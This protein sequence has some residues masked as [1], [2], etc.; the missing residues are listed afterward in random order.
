MGLLVASNDKLVAGN[1]V[2]SFSFD[3]FDWSDIA[4]H[5]VSILSISQLKHFAV[6]KIDFPRCNVYAIFWILS[7]CASQESY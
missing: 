1:F 2:L 7:T 5:P 6:K 3:R 4:K